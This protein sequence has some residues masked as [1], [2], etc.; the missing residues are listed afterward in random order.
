MTDFT[1]VRPLG[2]TLGSFS[3]ARL[4]D[5][6]AAWNRRRVTRNELYALTDRELDDIGLTRY[7]INGV[8][9]RMR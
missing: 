1:A 6:F 9:E 8:V 7:D 4:T 2:A 5:A 3:P